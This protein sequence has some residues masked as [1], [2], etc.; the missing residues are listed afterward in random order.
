MF[1]NKFSLLFIL[2]IVLKDKTCY[3]NLFF[4]VM[5]AYFCCDFVPLYMY[6]DFGA[7]IRYMYLW[8]AWV[9]TSRSVQWDEMYLYMP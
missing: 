2:G 9:I 4:Y 1:K 7:R 5:E 8:N 6:V 3:G